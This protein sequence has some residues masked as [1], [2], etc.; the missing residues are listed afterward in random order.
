[1]QLHRQLAD[2]RAGHAGTVAAAQ[3][4]G[5][6]R[7]IADAQLVQQQAQQPATA[8]SGKP[9]PAHI[10][11]AAL[12][13]TAL[14]STQPASST[15]AQDE[16]SCQSDER[17]QADVAPRS[18]LPAANVV[19]FASKQLVTAAAATQTALAIVGCKDS[20]G[21]A[22]KDASL[23][24]ASQ[25][26]MGSQQPAQGLDHSVVAA[27]DH[28]TASRSASVSAAIA[29]EAV[30][31]HAAKLCVAEPLV[32]EETQAVCSTQP[33]AAGSPNSRHADDEQRHKSL[34]VAAESGVAP[35]SK[36]SG[37]SSKQL[38]GAKSI[39]A[40]C[41]RSVV[42]VSQGSAE[43]QAQEE[44]EPVSNRSVADMFASLSYL[45]GGLASMPEAPTL[46]SATARDANGQP[47]CKK[48]RVEVS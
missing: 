39:A 32:D 7:R 4:A 38:A 17:I 25:G 1:V 12:L 5:V 33:P 41:K 43:H 24:M 37:R 19:H 11:C 13:A 16:L 40:T 9:R 14:H 44:Q 28:S 15:S 45:Q 21:A 46:Q 23:P 47:A 48:R 35:T 31:I 3:A 18:I 8:V 27:N 36:N 10:G 30:H 6:E 42:A 22:G 29:D 20:N 2:M 26:P 34:P